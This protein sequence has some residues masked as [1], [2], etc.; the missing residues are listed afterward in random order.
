M[1]VTQDLE[2]VSMIRLKYFCCTPN[3]AVS[4]HN[5]EQLDSRG[6]LTK[7]TRLV[8]PKIEKA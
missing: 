7:W 8:F 1:I 6:S 4:V 3:F 5:I 2:D